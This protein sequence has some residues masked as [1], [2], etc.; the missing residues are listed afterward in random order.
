[1]DGAPATHSECA[2]F[3]YNRHRIEQ[4]VTIEPQAQT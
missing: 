3:H 1:M 4:E 2:F